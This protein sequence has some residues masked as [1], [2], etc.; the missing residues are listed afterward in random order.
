M[1]RFTYAFYED[2]WNKVY[3][4]TLPP[5]YSKYRSLKLKTP[6]KI[7]PGEIKAVYIHSTLHSDKAI[8]YD[9]TDNTPFY[10]RGGRLPRGAIVPRYEDEKIVIHSGRAHVSP[11][12]FSNETLWGW[13][14]AWRDRREFV[15]TID[16][17]IVYKLWQPTIQVYSN[18]PNTFQ[19]G[20]RIL[21]MCQ[22][23]W[24]SNFS[25]LPDE[26]IF[27]ILNMC[28]YDWF[29]YDPSKLKKKK[30][31]QKRL[32]AS[33]SSAIMK[34]TRR[35]KR[36]KEIP[37]IAFAA[38]AAAAAT[39]TSTTASVTTA[40]VAT[41]NDDVDATTSTV[42]SSEELAVCHNTEERCTSSPRWK[43]ALRKLNVFAKKRN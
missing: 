30:K 19:Y 34:K 23:R 8:V 33:S 32:T 20:T 28:K 35:K 26:C 29:Y 5:S 24:E 21:F 12:A 15:G 27:Y 22:R 6:I 41:T 9:N 16:Y 4:K 10:H 3:S 18:F 7:R 31:K 39:A 43:G 11:V 1:A 13:G 36:D 17:G 38:A 40:A 25:K 14:G 37:A 2:A 42:A